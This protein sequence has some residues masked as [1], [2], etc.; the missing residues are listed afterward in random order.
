MKKVFFA[1][2]AF[3]VLLTVSSC[4]T[5]SK[6]VSNYLT[7][8]NF[9]EEHSYDQFA[10]KTKFH[11]SIDSLYD[12]TKVQQFCDTADVTFHIA[13]GGITVDA[14]CDG[15]VDKL[16]DLVKKVYSLIDFWK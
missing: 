9:K 16:K 7:S 8:H 4:G 13:R 12:Y 10:D 2:M 11:A 5:S 1:L 15:A 6:S 14:T 3:A